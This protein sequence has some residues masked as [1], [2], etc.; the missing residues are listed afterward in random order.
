[1]SADDRRPM[2]YPP[3]SPPVMFD[4]P[5]SEWSRSDGKAVLDWLV[6]LVTPRTDELLARLDMSWAD[7]PAGWLRLVEVGIRERI[8][9]NDLWQ[10]G[11]GPETIELRGRTIEQDLGPQLSGLGE[12]LGVDLG[13]LLAR[14]FVGHL[15]D[16]ARWIVGAHGRTYVS[17]MLPVLVGRGAM[18]FDPMLIGPN[19][20]RGWLPGAE[21]GHHTPDLTTLHDRW[22][23]MLSDPGAGRR[24]P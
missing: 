20:A 16:D 5:R 22:L 2:A 19:V 23:Q 8:W 15:G 4:R 10:P 17:R 21:A 13:L 12:A 7:R 1:M 3:L 24:R 6:S 9:T 18:E 11:N 14:S